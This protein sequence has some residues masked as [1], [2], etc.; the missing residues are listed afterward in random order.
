MKNF[1][2]TKSSS[3]NLQPLPT[4]T[5]G[6][7]NNSS[8]IT[9]Q[10]P[11]V[12]RSTGTGV[13]PHQ[14]SL[15]Q[16]ETVV[17]DPGHKKIQ[18]AVTKLFAALE[19]HSEK[20]LLKHAAKV[21]ESLA[22][23]ADPAADV[24]KHLRQVVNE[25]TNREEVLK[26]VNAVTEMATPRVKEDSVCMHLQ[27]LLNA[28]LLMLEGHSLVGRGQL[29][30]GDVVKCRQDADPGVINEVSELKCRASQL[31]K[32][33]PFFATSSTDQEKTVEER[34]MAHIR[35]TLLPIGVE[36]KSNRQLLEMHPSTGKRNAVTD[37]IA[38]RTDIAR[39][40]FAKSMEWLLTGGTPNIT[41]RALLRS[42]AAAQGMLTKLAELGEAADMNTIRREMESFMASVHAQRNNL[43]ALRDSLFSGGGAALRWVAMSPGSTGMDKTLV[44]QH[45]K[46]LDFI[47][48]YFDT[49]HGVIN[50]QLN[51]S[52]SSATSGHLPVTEEI[53]SAYM[54]VFRID[55]PLGT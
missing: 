24:R 21:T 47:K 17:V 42:A 23:G 52:A 50:D 7:N 54:V 53:K 37:E 33:A 40:S 32:S 5:R 14:P 6:S 25:M 44:H 31:L 29:I 9:Q 26:L 19:S 15:R 35:D 18:G 43:R 8:S 36:T 38:I 3:N 48:Q 1:F 30:G 20:D 39:L 28:K 12:P 41:T 10:P 51:I 4:A 11:N 49:L 16:R 2:S 45:E 22:G 13:Y 46:G 27:F 34:A 55:V